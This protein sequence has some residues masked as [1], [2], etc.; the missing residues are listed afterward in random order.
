MAQKSET[1]NSLD[2]LISGLKIFLKWKRLNKGY[3]H[4]S[5]SP[6]FPFH[7]GKFYYHIQAL[8]CVFTSSSE[9]PDRPRSR[10]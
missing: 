10:T 2:I 8:Y 4:A 7:L 9:L 3:F 6:W 5:L 1:K